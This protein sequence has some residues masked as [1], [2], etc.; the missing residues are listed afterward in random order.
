MNNFNFKNNKGFT[1]V[2]AIIAVF[3]LSVSVTSMLSLTATSFSSARYANSEITSNYLLQEAIDSI[4]NSRDTIVFQQKSSWDTFLNRYGYVGSNK[5][6]SDNGCIISTENYDPD[7]LDLLG[8]EIQQCNTSNISFGSLICPTLLYNPNGNNG[9]FYSYTSGVESDFK[10]Q[11][12]ME[13]VDADEVRVVATV[14]WKNGN[15]VKTR[16]L[17]TSL[18]NWQK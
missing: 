5:C 13:I 2:E 6:F 17:E 1:V 18:L 11:V 14:E 3:M 16:S 10:R 15:S 9:S 12:K 8:L 7:S 4:R